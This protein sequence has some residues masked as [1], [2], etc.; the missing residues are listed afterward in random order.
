MLWHAFAK[1]QVSISRQSR[2]KKR[3]VL[4]I[5]SFGLRDEVGGEHLIKLSQ[6]E[7]FHR[8]GPS[9]AAAG[10]LVGTEP[11]RALASVALA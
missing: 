4:R 8:G 7:Q 11:R 2:G 10:L 9:P 5:E 6:H 1:M 3:F